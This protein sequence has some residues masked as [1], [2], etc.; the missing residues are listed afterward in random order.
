M[1][2][3]T[4]PGIDVTII[5]HHYELAR[6]TTFIEDDFTGPLL[7]LELLAQLQQRGSIRHIHVSSGAGPR[8][9]DVA[10]L[11]V[12]ATIVGREYTE[13]A[14]TFERCVNGRV[15]DISKR[16]ISTQLA[17]PG[18]V[19]PVIAKSNLNYYGHPERLLNA[20]AT[21]QGSRC[22]FPTPW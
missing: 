10:I 11:H 15:S 14:A 7:I 4:R 22:R 2:R 21:R 6:F 16:T 9:S 13:F 19:G 1:N 17:G 12:N 18:T 20:R 3:R 8:E 5:V